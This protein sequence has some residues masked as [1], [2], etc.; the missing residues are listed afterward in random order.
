MKIEWKPPALKTTLIASWQRHERNREKQ[1][2]RL[3]RSGFANGRRPDSNGV[4]L[5]SKVN[6]LPAIGSVVVVVFSESAFWIYP[7]GLV[8]V[9][10]V[11]VVCVVV[12]V[13]VVAVSSAR[14]SFTFSVSEFHCRHLSDSG[15]RDCRRWR[16]DWNGFGKREADRSA[17][18]SLA[19]HHQLCLARLLVSCAERASEC[20]CA[21]R[22]Q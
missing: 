22:K 19:A 12:V 3:S 18:Y 14:N 15:G 4:R 2:R 13:A 7:A 6:W 10:V 17:P 11:V 20:V 5:R 21:M 16:L 9:V 8:F 1:E